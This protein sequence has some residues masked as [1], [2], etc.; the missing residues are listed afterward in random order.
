M[1]EAM[2]DVSMRLAPVSENEANEMIDQLRGAKILGPFRGMKT[3]DRQVMTQC[4]VKVSQL[5]HHFSEIVEMDINPMILSDDGNVGMAL[6]ARV[7]F[8]NGTETQTMS[9]SFNKHQHI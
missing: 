1:V 3:V 6:D 2:Q 4:L 8:S 7:I 9:P 5:M